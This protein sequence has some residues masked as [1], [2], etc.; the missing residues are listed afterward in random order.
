MD[1]AIPCSVC[2]E[3]G[4]RPRKCPALHEMLKEGFYAGGG[5]GGGHSHD[6]DDEKVTGEA[7]HPTCPST[8]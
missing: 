7:P 2:N 3:T 5:G 4:H 1:S 6:D 8:Q